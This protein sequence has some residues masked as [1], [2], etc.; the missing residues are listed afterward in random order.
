M[1][2]EVT[3]VFSGNT[4]DTTRVWG[5]DIFSVMLNAYQ[6]AYPGFPTAMVPWKPN[7]ITI[8]PASNFPFAFTSASLVHDP[9]NAPV[10]LVPDQLTDE[11]KNEILRLSP[12]G[13]NVPAQIF[14]IGPISQIVER[15]IH[16]LGF[17]TLRIGNQNPY[18]TSMEVSQFRLRYPATQQGRKNAFL[19]SGETF[20]ESM[21]VP[22]YA[23]HQGIPVLLSE[24]ERIPAAIQQFFSVHPEVNVYIVGTNETISKGV[25]QSLRRYTRGK[26]VRIAGTSPFDISVRFSKFFDAETSVGWNRN[27]K[28]IGDAFSFVNRRDWRLA[29]ISGL[30]SH[31]G[32]H[33]PLLLTRSGGLPSEVKEY[34]LLLRPGMKRPPRPPFMHGYVFGN[35]DSIDYQTQ[36]EIEENIIFPRME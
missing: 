34:L 35:F 9:Y 4:V 1:L 31:L 17:S 19:I 2:G 3:E 27:K 13:K 15:E 10:M 32:K 18:H 29:I 22:N 11:I 25:E 6:M 14:L 23:M 7:A 30:F 16:A 21:F 5:E 24:K 33:A 36:I 26:V 12:E 28:G 8:V 20:G